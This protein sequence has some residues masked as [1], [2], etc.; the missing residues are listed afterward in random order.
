[1]TE[2]RNK[3]H[4]SIYFLLYSGKH[5]EEII[6]FL[7]HN[8]LKENKYPAI[9]LTWEVRDQYNEN[10]KPLKKE[11]EKELENGKITHDH[12]LVKLILQK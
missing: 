5:K 7:L 3:L 10:F 6:S 11:T 8:S 9:N 1:M 12:G 2:Y 4:K